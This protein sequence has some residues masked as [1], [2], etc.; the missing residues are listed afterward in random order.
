MILQTSIERHPDKLRSASRLYL[1][2]RDRSLYWLL[3]V[4]GYGA[5]LMRASTGHEDG[6]LQF[7]GVSIFTDEEIKFE[8]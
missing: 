5:L 8:H 1:E 7:D 3:E 6:K 4:R 2:E